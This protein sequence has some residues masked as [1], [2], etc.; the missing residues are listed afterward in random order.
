MQGDVRVQQAVRVVGKLAA[1]SQHAAKNLVGRRRPARAAEHK[2]LASAEAAE[3][4]TPVARRCRTAGVDLYTYDWRGAYD[5]WRRGLM[6]SPQ[7]PYA[8][9]WA[10]LDMVHARCVR[11]CED[12]CGR[13][14][15]SESEPCL[16][17]AHGLPGSGKSAV[18]LWLTQYFEQVWQWTQGVHFVKVAF[19]NS[20]A[21]NIDGSTIHSWGNIGF[22]AKD[23][24][25]CQ[26]CTVH[27]LAMA[28]EGQRLVSMTAGHR[29]RRAHH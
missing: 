15:P 17:L 2:V 29:G 6:G 13:T 3:E 9:Q 7:C 21:A 10:I 27:T 26:P 4:E 23:V 20:M 11:E 5:T 12:S 28:I 24:G 8:E 14:S 18:L 1:M 25:M 16:R 22:V 19:M